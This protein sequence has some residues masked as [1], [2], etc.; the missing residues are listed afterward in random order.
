LTVTIAK[1]CVVAVVVVSAR[2]FGAKMKNDTKHQSTMTFLFYTNATLCQ[3]CRAY[4][5]DCVYNPQ[6]LSSHDIDEEK[7]EK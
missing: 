3:K 7:K 5:Q 2:I 6:T 4:M 1:I